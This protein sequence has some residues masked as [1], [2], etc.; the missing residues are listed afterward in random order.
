MKNRFWKVST[1]KKSPF[2]IVHQKTER[3]G[4]VTMCKKSKNPKKPKFGLVVLRTGPLIF[5]CIILF[6]SN[7]LHTSEMEGFWWTKCPRDATHLN[8]SHFWWRIWISHRFLNNC[9]GLH[10]RPQNS[11]IG[12][13]RHERRFS[14]S[15]QQNSRT[16]IM[17]ARGCLKLPRHPNLIYMVFF[18]IAWRF[19][20]KKISSN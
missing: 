1:H 3:S 13:L 8:F 14:G 11:F 16:S 5:F 18:I 17:H 10:F 12:C 7:P 15:K 4:S 9:Y 19:P 20:V 2:F 6:Q